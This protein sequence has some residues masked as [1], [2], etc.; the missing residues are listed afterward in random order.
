[1]WYGLNFAFT[2]AQVT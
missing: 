2:R 1:M